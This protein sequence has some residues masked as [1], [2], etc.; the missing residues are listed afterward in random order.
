MAPQGQ[1][2]LGPRGPGPFLN[3]QPPQPRLEKNR[4]GPKKGIVKK[5]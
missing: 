3:M 2:A 5:R 4:K 1:Y